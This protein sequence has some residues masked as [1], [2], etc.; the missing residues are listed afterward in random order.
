VQY[1]LLAPAG[2]LASRLVLLS[3][4]RAAFFG[5]A[6]MVIASLSRKKPAIGTT[7]SPLTDED[8]IRFVR[9]RNDKTAVQ[10]PTTVITP[11]ETRGTRAGP[12]SGLA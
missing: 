4:R 2:W 3:E 7:A 6:A 10:A 11:F 9:Q 12:F 5:R 8:S 1:G